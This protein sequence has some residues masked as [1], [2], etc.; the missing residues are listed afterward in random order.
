MIGYG[1]M[2]PPGA[3]WWS[4]WVGRWYNAFMPLTITDEQLQSLGLD[5]R[6]A[7]IEFACRL[8]DAEKL[9]L[10]PAAKLAGLS[11]VEMEDELARRGIAIYRPTLAD[12][13][14]DL[15]TI[16]HLEQTGR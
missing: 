10:W 8:F 12:I 14:E 16:S 6:E 13:K 7:R 1:F 5:E 9:Q 11:R 3:A 4:E 15:R 2:G